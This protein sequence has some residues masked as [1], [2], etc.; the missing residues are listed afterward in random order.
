M[1]KEV[2][3]IRLVDCVIPL[4]NCLVCI[5]Q[6][7]AICYKNMVWGRDY[8]HFK[9]ELTECLDPSVSKEARR[10]AAQL[11][12][13]LA[14]LNELVTAKI[15]VKQIS[16]LLQILDSIISELVKIGA[17]IPCDESESEF[18]ILNHNN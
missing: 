18:A 9:G 6:D 7:G 11:F 10:G 12:R 1:I 4:K 3:F 14:A 17:L 15:K 13:E 8:S 5:K 16:V 2:Y